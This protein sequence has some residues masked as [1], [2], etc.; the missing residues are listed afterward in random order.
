MVWAVYHW[1]RY[2]GY[3]VLRRAHVPGRF[4]PHFLWKPG[5]RKPMLHFV[6]VRKGIIF[7]WPIFKGYVKMGDWKDWN[8]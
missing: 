3:L 8:R 1:L 4:Y 2:G 7:P 5:K 6:P